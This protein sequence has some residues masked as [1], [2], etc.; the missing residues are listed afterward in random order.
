[1][2]R[3]FVALLLVAAMQLPSLSMAQE[4]LGLEA[5]AEWGGENIQLPP[6]FAPDMN[7]KGME[8]IRFAPG[9]MQAESST[10]FS[11]AFAFEVEPE[12]K[13]TEVLLEKEFLKYYRG[14]CSAVLGGSPPE[15]ELSK[16]TFQMKAATGKKETKPASQEY[17]A[18]LR[19]VEPFATKR[20]QTLRLEIRT[21]A[22]DQHTYLFACVSPHE[23]DDEIWKQL[24]RIRDDYFQ[25]KVP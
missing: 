21:W 15:L 24:H 5:P 7:L 12:P 9:M 13:L 2:I 11:Y 8:Y 25:S 22:D 19:W 10:F 23:A 17:V 4:K 18:T 6:T 14:L 16:F 20:I 1:M 3:T